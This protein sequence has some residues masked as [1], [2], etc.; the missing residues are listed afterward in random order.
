M[1][2]DYLGLTRTYE[3]DLI[4]RKNNNNIFELDIEEILNRFKNRLEHDK[5]TLETLINEDP[6][7][8]KKKERK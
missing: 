1:K 6:R 7:L 8:N 2:F 5:V 3:I 4:I